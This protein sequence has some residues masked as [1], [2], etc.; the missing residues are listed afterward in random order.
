MQHRIV[1]VGA[2]GTGRELADRLA[3]RHEVMLVDSQPA[4]LDDH[5]ADHGEKIGPDEPVKVTWVH[6]DGTSRLVLKELFDSERSCSLVATAGT[7]EVNL[8]VGRLGRAIGFDPVIAIQHER[9]SAESYRQERITALDRTQLLAGQVERSIRHHGAVLPTGVGLGKGE[10]VEIHL[11][12]TSPLLNMPLKQLAPQKWRVAAVFRD[13]E[14][15]VPT[16]D[17]VL[18]VDDRVLLVGDPEILPAVAEYLHLGLPQFPRPFG[19]NVVTLERG[20]P[21][22]ALLSE[23]DDLA[24]RCG[25]AQVCRGLPGATPSAGPPEHEEPLARPAGERDDVPHSTFALPAL[26]AAEIGETLAPQRPGVLVTRAIARPWMARLLGIRGEDAELCDCAASPVLFARGSFPHERILL[27]VSGSILDI[28]AA[29]VAIDV[30]RQLDGALTAVNVDLPRYISGTPEERV[31]EEVVPVR[32]LFE[33]YNV[34]L[35][36]HHHEGNPIQHLLAESNQQDLVVLARWRRRRDTYFDPDV[37]LRVAR[38][39]PC[40]AL[41]LT[42]D[43]KE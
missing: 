20:G 27:P 19:P 34:S 28:H 36:Y 5:R 21:D 17:T 31:H 22:R 23:A 12:Q 37:A 29:E 30:A 1:I 13:D 42:V 26:G 9:E 43:H 3:P 40:S 33:L 7:D 6:A 32:R 25:A 38:R 24:R 39:A 4:S 14:L 41:V 15:I 2:G 35:D 10:L 8:E 16:G 11:L 18:Q